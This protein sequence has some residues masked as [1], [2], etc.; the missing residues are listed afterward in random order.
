MYELLLQPYYKNAF[1]YWVAYVDTEVRQP[2]TPVGEKFLEWLCENYPITIN[3]TQNG[4]FKYF[5]FETEADRTI[6][7]LRWG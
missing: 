6:F 4:Y 5:H 2:T 7:M 1:A 3:T